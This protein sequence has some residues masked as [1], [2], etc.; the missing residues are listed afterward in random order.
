MNCLEN[1]EKKTDLVTVGEIFANTNCYRIPDYQRGYAWQDEFKVLWDDVIRVYRGGEEAK[2]HYTGMLALKEIKDQPAKEKE[3]VI[4]RNAFFVVDGQQRLTSIVILIKAL[5]EYIVGEGGTVA[6][7]LSFSD[8][9]YRFDYS[10]DYSDAAKSF[11]EKRIYLAHTSN[12]VCADLYCKNISRAKEYIDGL[13]V[14]YSCKEAEEILS[15]VE[16]KLFFNIYFVDE[17]FD[18]RVTFETMNNRGKKL[19]NLELLKNRLMYLTTFIGSTEESS[20]Y[21][22][23]LNSSINKAWSNIYANLCYQNYQLNDDEYL[24]AH[25]CIFGTLNKNKGD[26]YIRYLLGNYFSIDEGVFPAE[27]SNKEFDKAYKL[28]KDYVDSLEEYSGFWGIVNNPTERLNQSN[29]AESK[30]MN[31]LAQLN[32]ETTQI[33]IRA[34]EMAIEGN[35]YLSND[36]KVDGYKAIE[37]SLFVNVLVGGLRND[38]SSLISP[39]RDLLRS[40]S[41]S[42]AIKSYEKF[43]NTLSSG[44]LSVTDDKIRNSFKHL[45]DELD[46]NNRPD[47]YYSW[48]DLRYL[49]Y[50]YNDSLKIKGT[51]IDWSGL[52]AESIEHILP[53]TPS[54]DYWKIILLPISSDEKAITRIINSLGNLLLLSKAGNS[55]V[56]NYSFR[57]KAFGVDHDDSFAY[58]FGSRSAQEVARDFKYWS[59]HSI[60]SRQR[61]LVD[62]MYSR[63]I[64]GDGISM[65]QDEFAALLKSSNL[66]IGD[67]PEISEETKKKLDSLDLSSER[68][69]ASQTP[70]HDDE[71]FNSLYR[72]FDFHG[73]EIRKNQSNISYVKDRFTFKKTNDGIS[74]GF[75]ID[76]EKRL[77]FGYYEESNSICVSEEA[78]GEWRSLSDLSSM[79]SQAVFFVNSLN[80]WLR[81]ERNKPEAL[82]SKG[83]EDESEK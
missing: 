24:R 72:F 79:P 62:F 11:F 18:V 5:Q 6:D 16:D 7:V 17:K 29:E 10:K 23:I 26:A 22:S 56:R 58:V 74:C 35:K 46:P 76:K 38:Y 50:E 66:L 9:T 4:G 15:I 45:G 82:I 3:S 67:H 69:A 33:Y 60:Y 68:K 25:W 51:A 39:A 1:P 75:E 41:E 64:V 8:G 34:A 63:W 57:T 13:L 19:S 30:R 2:P 65:S 49:L 37:R 47:F 52:S 42:E 55:G 71:W 12:V 21:Q 83:S 54:R 36:E 28:I 44:E 53:Q 27:I 40:K 80:R 32:R 78:G 77:W 14:S 70:T 61:E 73:Y 48:K 59:L 43:I 20:N 81:H 31:V